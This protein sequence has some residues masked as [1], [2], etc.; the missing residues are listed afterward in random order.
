MEKQ[1]QKVGI[2]GISGRMGR[3]VAETIRGASE[4][5]LAGGWNRTGRSHLPGVPV[6]STPD[7]LL[8][9]SD[10]VVDFS[11]PEASQRLLKA[12]LEQPKPLVCGTTALSDDTQGLLDRLALEQPVIYDTNFSVGIAVLNQLLRQACRLLG[13]GFDVEIVETHHRRKKDAPSGTAVRLAQTL[14]QQCSTNE[15]EIPVQI[16]RQG[17]N[18]TRQNE[19]VIHALRGGSITGEHTVYF[20]GE[21]EVLCLEHRALDRNLFVDGVLRAL[22]WISGQG[23]GRFSMEHVL[24]LKP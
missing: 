2:S 13:P 15:S 11:Q 24:Q 1:K 20:L 6:F 4:F 12:L 3:L 7:E 23:P 19:V 10:V 22:R 9:V 21:H 8:V 16:G 17:T 5:H 14:A 18:L